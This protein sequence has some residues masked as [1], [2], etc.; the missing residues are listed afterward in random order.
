M[1]AFSTLSASLPTVD[2]PQVWADGLGNPSRNAI[3]QCQV[4]RLLSLVG[5]LEAARTQAKGNPSP[6]L[7]PYRLWIDTLCCPVELSGKHIALER[8]KNVYI[9][10]AHVLVL[11]SFISS[12]PY[13]GRP[14]AEPVLRILATSSWMRRLWT[15]QGWYSPHSLGCRSCL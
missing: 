11:D 14:A 5:D 15:L 1:Y 8:I 13:K 9:E 7:S 3:Q 2:T 12:F 10:A 4:T 6:Q